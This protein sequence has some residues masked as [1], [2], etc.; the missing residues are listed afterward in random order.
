MENKK[1]I[2]NS[3]VVSILSK[4][5]WFNIFSYIDLK[6]FFNLEKS[7]KFFRKIFLEYYLE[8]NTINEE[9]INHKNKIN[10][11]EAKPDNPED[12]INISFKNSF[13]KD[14][15]KLKK[16]ILEKYCN[17][18]IQIPYEL[19]EFCGIYIQTNQLNIYLIMI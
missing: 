17:F 2:N 4:E 8:T 14:I 12:N 7:S 13:F 5:K 16:N 10:K 11:T 15:K 9:A 18:L 6:S 1:Q 3:S 19:V